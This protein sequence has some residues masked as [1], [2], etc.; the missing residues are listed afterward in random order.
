[1]VDQRVSESDDVFFCDLAEGLIRPPAEK[2]QN[3][4]KTRL[5]EVHGGG[6]D[7]RLLEVH[8]ALPGSFSP[9]DKRLY[10]VAS[11]RR[12]RLSCL[13][14]RHLVVIG[15]NAVDLLAGSQ[16]VFH[17]RLALL[18]LPVAGLF[19]GDFDIGELFLD[20][21]LNPLVRPWAGSS[22]SSPIR[23]AS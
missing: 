16:P 9:D 1:L 14:E 12:G 7:F 23:M 4:P 11:D 2:V 22:L 18:A 19:A 15:G 5:I 10:A 21:L 6:C 8:A 13:A 17:D 3:F 20:D